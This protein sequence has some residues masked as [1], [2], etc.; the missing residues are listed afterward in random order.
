MFLILSREKDEQGIEI[1][2]GKLTKLIE[3]LY[4]G[5]AKKTDVPYELEVIVYDPDSGIDEHVIQK[6]QE[7]FKG[8]TAFGKKVKKDFWN[9]IWRM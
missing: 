6:V 5:N 9:N 2:N 1:K 4:Y 8:N 7:L 3:L